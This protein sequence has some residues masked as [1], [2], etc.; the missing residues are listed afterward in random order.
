MIELSFQDLPQ[1]EQNN[2][3]VAIEAQNKAYAPYS[4]FPVGALAISSNGKKFNGCNIESVDYTLTSHAEMTAINN[5]VSSG[6]QKLQKIYI[7][8]KSEQIPVP[9]GLCRQKMIEFA[10]QDDMKIITINNSK[11]E[12]KIYQFTLKELYPYPFSKK[13]L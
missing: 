2:I 11:E 1:E 6:E 9:C 5:M 13:H 8:L 4:H 12:L 10:E 7:S 3:Q